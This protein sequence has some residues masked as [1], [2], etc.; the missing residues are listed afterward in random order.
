MRHHLLI[1]L[2]LH[3]KVFTETLYVLSVSRAVSLD[4][5]SVIATESARQKAI[6]ELLAPQTGQFWALKHAY[7]DSFKNVKFSR[8]DILT[9]SEHDHHI[10]DINSTERSY[11][12][13]DLIL[14][15]VAAAVAE[16]DVC[17]HAVVGGG[18]RTMSVYLAMAMQILARSQDRLYHLVVDPWEVET[19][20]DFYFPPPENKK[21]ITNSGRA[22]ESGQ[23]T[24]DLTDIPFIR[25]RNRLSLPDTALAS[26]SRTLLSWVQTELNGALVLPE[27]R[28]DADERCLTVGSER[29]TLQPQQFALYWY[30]A[31]RSREA[32]KTSRNEQNYDHYFEAAHSPYFSDAMGQGVL[33]RLHAL[34]PKGGKTEEFSRKVLDGR[35]LPMEW[36]LQKISRINS[37]LKSRVRQAHVLP[38]ITI[39]SIG[40]RGEKR[41]GIKH[42][43]TKIHTPT[44]PP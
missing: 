21:I 11:A 27:L 6:T 38:Y 32:A 39:S 44:V 34:D 14:Q 22:Y 15:T 28:L 26:S 18:R 20:S 41:Y 16:D 25:L 33:D 1:L 29:I 7:P 2:G 40:R 35:L 31:D 43:G 36:V 3:P 5:I 17:L 12:F 23:V 30:F 19:G 13:F 4:K 37:C 10:W 8:D 42:P 24:V 9:A